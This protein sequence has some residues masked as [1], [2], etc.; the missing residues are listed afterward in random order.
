MVAV[1]WKA[2]AA[3]RLKDTSADDLAR[4]STSPARNLDRLRAERGTLSV[5][6]CDIVG[7]T[8]LSSRLEPEDLSAVLR[9]YQSRVAATIARFGGFIARYVG[10]GVLV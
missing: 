8:T 10:D 7:L 6:F 1:S 5:M 3:L 9:G 2:I 4:L